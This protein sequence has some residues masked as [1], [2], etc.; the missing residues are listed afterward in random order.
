[1][2]PD[3]RFTL[4]GETRQVH[5]LLDRDFKAMVL[6]GPE[7]NPTGEVG[8]WTMIYDQGLVVELPSRK[9]KYAANFRYSLKP[10]VTPDKYDSLK[11]SS[12]ESFDSVCDQTMVGVKFGTDDKAVQCWLGYQNRP[13]TTR[14]AR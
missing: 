3:L 1:M 8:D 10:S 9:A 13:L 2:S 7:G 12:Y 11:C 6:N 4:P 5:L 14:V